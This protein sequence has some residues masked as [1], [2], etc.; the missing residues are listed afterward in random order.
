MTSRASAGGSFDTFGSG[1]ATVLLHRLTNGRDVVDYVRCSFAEDTSWF[2]PS[3]AASNTSCLT[4]RTWSHATIGT[5]VSS[6]HSRFDSILRPPPFAGVSS[7]HRRLFHSIRT[8]LR[9]QYHPSSHQRHTRSFPTLERHGARTAARRTCRPEAQGGP[10]SEGQS[11]GP[12][13]DG[14]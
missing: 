2:V 9:H 4:T 6:S 8:S 14:P 1:T 3:T 12:R 5:A 10:R 11:D 7:F 13:Q